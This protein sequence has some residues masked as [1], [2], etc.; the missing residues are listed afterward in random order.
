MNPI[1]LGRLLRHGW[2][3][4]MGVL[5]FVGGLLCGMSAQKQRNAASLTE[6]DAALREAAAQLTHAADALR[7]QHAANRRLAAAAREA[8]QREAA[9]LQAAQAEKVRL[10]RE[11]QAFERRLQ[12]A[13][14]RPDCRMLLETDV[15]QVCGNLH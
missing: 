6:K 7:Q 15:R 12:Q 2:P 11:S 1:L 3:W 4:L 9:A 13:R 14:R 5:L 8:T 10:A